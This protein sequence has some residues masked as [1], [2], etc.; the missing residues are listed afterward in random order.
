MYYWTIS[1]CNVDRILVTGNTLVCEIYHQTLN[2]IRTKFPN[3]IVSRLV[4]Q[5][6]FPNPLKPAAKSRMKMQF[7]QGRQLMLPIHLSDQQ[8][9]CRP[10]FDL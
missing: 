3:I 5:L 8:F 1:F 9:Y 10:R 2:I 7:E 4:L 6:Y